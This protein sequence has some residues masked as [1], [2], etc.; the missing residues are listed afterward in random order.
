MKFKDAYEK[1][2]RN[3]ASEEER[4]FVEEQIEQFQ[5]LMDISVEDE[6]K[7]DILQSDTG[8]YEQ[9]NINLYKNI[10][11][12]MSRKRIKQIGCILL[13]ICLIPA[14]F[15]VWKGVTVYDFSEKEGSETVYSNMR[16]I[17]S[18]LNSPEIIRT[19]TE[20]EKAGFGKYDLFSSE[21]PTLLRSANRKTNED[22]KYRYKD[23]FYKRTFFGVGAVYE[24]NGEEN[25]MSPLGTIPTM[26]MIDN[27]TT[28]DVEAI[29][30]MPKN[31]IF[32]IYVKLDKERS[33]E[34]ILAI[35]NEFKQQNID[36]GLRWMPI[37]YGAFEDEQYKSQYR[38]E[39]I[40]FNFHYDL[41][42]IE[43]F[44]YDKQKYPLLQIGAEQYKDGV[45]QF[46]KVDAKMYRTHV[47]SLLNYVFDHEEF[48]SSFQWDLAAEE[49]ARDI[50][51]EQGIRSDMVYLNIQRDS[52]IELIQAGYVESGCITETM[53]TF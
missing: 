13:V 23:T 8:T 4:A 6:V 14:L 30:S 2:K 1:Y 33:L 11:Q 52:L 10:K 35:D 34:E 20:V 18:E 16:V 7:E 47:D 15:N 46:D 53:H 43:I 32:S 44:D 17:S 3:E 21:Y 48:I 28:L 24:R 29:E 22:M 40:G 19:K 25:F 39:A 49:K 5:I 50:L 26:S 51:H 37:Y 41:A 12:A 38:Q 9:Y 36:I 27:Q 42:P 31:T 45:Q